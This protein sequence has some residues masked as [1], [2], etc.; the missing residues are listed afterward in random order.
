MRVTS[1]GSVQRTSPAI[2]PVAGFLI[3]A[4]PVNDAEVEVVSDV[5]VM[6][7]C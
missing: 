6:S 7:P 3:V 4:V 1:A 5:A 2:P